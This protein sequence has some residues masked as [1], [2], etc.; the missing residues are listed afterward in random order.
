MTLTR[1]ATR[2]GG[3]AALL[4][5]VA[6]ASPA[7]AE[8]PTSARGAG[9]LRDL[10]LITAQPTD[11]ATAQVTCSSPVSWPQARARRPAFGQSPRA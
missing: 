4:L 2:I 7:G 10:Q 1:A 6:T 11:H 9:Q 3:A 5:A 8:A